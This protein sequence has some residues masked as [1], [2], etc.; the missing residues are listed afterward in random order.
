MGWLRL[1]LRTA[2]VAAAV[3]L[4]CAL[5]LRRRRERW[6]L[7]AGAAALEIAL[8]CGLFALWQ[9]ANAATHL[10]AAGAHE[11]GRWLWDLERHLR[12]PDEGAM[13]DAVLGH[14]AIV[15]AANTY[16]ATAHLTGMAVFLGWLWLR[17]RDRYP[18]WRWVLVV[19]TALSLLVQI[20]PVAP[21]R[22]IAVGMVDTAQVYHQSVYQAL[23]SGVADQYAAMPSIHVGWALLVAAAC[24]TCGGRL[25]RT[26]GVA[27][28]VLTAVVVVVTAN[29]YWL[30]GIAAAALLLGA[31]AAVA[32]VRS[33]QETRSEVPSFTREPAA[34]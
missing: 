10:H 29:H 18:R 16:Y 26:V 19:F 22:L 24:W 17:H 31:W 14:P 27:H 33:R 6:S 12:L 34:V 15:R 23:G 32:A 28:A 7:I 8:V 25:A 20:L 1:D 9:V 21:P 11:R 13:Q 2:S 5:V 3:L 30:D 4:L